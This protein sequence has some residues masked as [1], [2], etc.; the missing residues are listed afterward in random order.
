MSKINHTRPAATI[1]AVRVPR[2]RFTKILL[3][4]GVLGILAVVFG[5]GR[6]A[7]GPV[8]SP[9]ASDARP[10][11]TV[12]DPENEALET[13]IEAGWYGDPTDQIEA[14][15]S[16]DTCRVVKVTGLPEN[17]VRLLTDRGFTA[18]PGDGREALYAPACR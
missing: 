3:V 18:R 6:A 16:P 8:T 7:A 17:V 13:L 4:A 10:V 1:T 9:T 5:L 14:L 11:A 15:Y 2:K 12:S